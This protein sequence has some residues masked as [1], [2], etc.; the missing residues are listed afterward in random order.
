MFYYSSLI[1]WVQIDGLGEKNVWFRPEFTNQSPFHNIG[2][3]FY[4]KI[5]FE[6]QHFN[7]YHHLQGPIML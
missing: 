4:G 5:D 3:T 1:V 7:L 2:L 6:L